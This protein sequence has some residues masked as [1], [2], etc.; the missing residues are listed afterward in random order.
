MKKFIRTAALMSVL[1]LTAAP[2][3][4]AE[5]MGTDPRPQGPTKPAVSMTSIAYTVLAYFG[6]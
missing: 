1:S 2:M 3:L 5:P 6:L 4:I